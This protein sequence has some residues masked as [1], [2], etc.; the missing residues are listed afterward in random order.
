MGDIHIREARPA[1]APSIAAANSEGVPGVT[2]MDAGE[3]ARI[4]ENAT[5]FLVAEREGAV[6]GYLMAY[7][8]GTP[9]QG[10]EYLWF[11]ERGDDFLYVDQIAV[12][13]RA[14]GSGVGRALYAEAAQAAR[15]RA[16]STLVCEV[17]V[18]PPNPESMAFHRRLGF[19][20]VGRLRVRLHDRHVAL[21]RR[22]L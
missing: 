18:D 6:C 1:D 20:E 13:G 22:P 11:N 17:N 14:R 16:L 3:A 8:P 9:Y 4:M 10:E 2:Q 19:A 15:E 7:A 12:T 5:L 21:M